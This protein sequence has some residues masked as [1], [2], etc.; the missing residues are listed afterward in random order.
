MVVSS[1]QFEELSESDDSA[2][3]HRSSGSRVAKSFTSS[4]SSFL[5]MVMAKT[6]ATHLI[7]ACVEGLDT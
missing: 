4:E 5:P 7:E 6:G 1:E 3:S 2:V